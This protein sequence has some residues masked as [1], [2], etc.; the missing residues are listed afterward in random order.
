MENGTLGADK[1]QALQREVIATE[2]DLEKLEKQVVHSNET[3]QKIGEVGDKFKEVGEGISNAGKKLVPLSASVAAVGAASM[4]AWNQMDEAMDNIQA[5]T[6]ATSEQMDGLSDTFDKV[7]GS[8][9]FSA[10]EVSD[11][12]AGISQKLGLTGQS[13]QDASEQF[14]KFSEVTGTDVSTAVESVGKAMNDAKIPA[15][16]VGS[17]LD[18]LT[19]ASQ[20]TGISVDK[21]TNLLDLNGVTMRQLGMSTDQEIAMLATMEKNGVDVSSV[22]MGLKFATKTYAAENKNASVEIQK[23]FDNIKNGSASAA[24]AQAVFGTRAGTILYQYVKEGKLDYQDLVNTIQ[25]SNGKLS[26]TF[27]ATEDPIDK[28]KVAYNNL[29][30]AGSQLGLG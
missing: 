20:K 3:L 26:E 28:M 2:E 9:P 22:L 11:A 19:V 29:K 24:D 30:I 13:L 5:K 10:S 23:L 25:Q 15:D 4:A 27:E 16:Q 17:V 6:G 14:L 8:V 18:K 21:L 12:I 7:F 1:Y